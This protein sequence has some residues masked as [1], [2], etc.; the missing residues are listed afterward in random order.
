MFLVLNLDKNSLMTDIIVDVISV[1]IHLSNIIQK[2]RIQSLNLGYIGKEICRQFE[3]MNN[4]LM[5]SR[6]ENRESINEDET[7]LELYRLRQAA[8]LAAIYHSEEGK[9]KRRTD[10]SHIVHASLH[11]VQFVRN[12]I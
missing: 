11:C 4:D 7:A 8:K 9:F 3:L 1:I 12:R 10:L 6:T 5:V 2:C